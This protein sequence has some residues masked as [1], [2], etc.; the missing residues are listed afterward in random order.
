M[1]KHGINLVSNFVKKAALIIG[2]ALF[3]ITFRV[4]VTPIAAV[5]FY[6]L[7]LL[8]Y[9]PSSLNLLDPDSIENFLQTR[10]KD[11]YQKLKGIRDVLEPLCIRDIKPCRATL[12]LQSLL[13]GDNDLAEQQLVSALNMEP[14][15]DVFLL[16]LADLYHI[17]DQAYLAHTHY[18]KLLFGSALSSEVEGQLHLLQGNDQTLALLKKARDLASSGKFTSS[19]EIYE[20][21]LN[22]FPGHLIAAQE[23]LFLARETRDTRASYFEGHLRQVSLPLDKRFCAYSI[24]SV[25]SLLQTQQWTQEFSEKVASIL[26]WSGCHWPTS[27][28]SF[29]EYFLNSVPLDEVNTIDR[30][31]DLCSNENNFKLSWYDSFGL[32]RIGWENKPG[33]MRLQPQYWQWLIWD[34]PQ[35]QKSSWYGGLE[36]INPGN[37]ALR[38][39]G[40]WID[41]LGEGTNPAA[42]FFARMPVTLEPGAQVLLVVRYRTSSR[43]K[44]AIWFGGYHWLE[45]SPDWTEVRIPYQNTSSGLREITPVLYLFNSETIWFKDFAIC[46]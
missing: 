16:M 15:N 23:G 28:A 35:H 3:V 12:A 6:R 30:T 42:G 37:Y 17:T 20:S 41:S 9:Y 38:I 39:S 4:K 27:A 40:L 31:G 14:D 46:G 19:L 36:T 10:E 29:E 25:N 33:M 8:K 11:S 7:E 5:N 44:P 43:A 26:V 21:I 34:K 24:N 32:P 22:L 2:F 1:K 18:Q 13:L 45:P